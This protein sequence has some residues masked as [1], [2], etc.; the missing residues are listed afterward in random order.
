[1]ARFDPL[2]AFFLKFFEVILLVLEELLERT[3]AFP[4]NFVNVLGFH[5]R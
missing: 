2:R 5:M 4:S 1:M 3:G